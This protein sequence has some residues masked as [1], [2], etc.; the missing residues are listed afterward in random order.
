MLTPNADAQENRDAWKQQSGISRTEAKRRYITTLIDTMHQYASRSPDALELVAELEF[1][2]DQVK[3]NVPSSSSSSPL[4]K[5]GR[6]LPDTS[7]TGARARDPVTSMGF[8]Q[9]A[10]HFAPQVSGGDSAGLREASPSSQEE[11]EEIEEIGD[12][13]FVDAPDSQ[14]ERDQYLRSGRKKAEGEE[15]PVD[16]KATAVTSPSSPSDQR[17]RRRIE[18]ALVKMTAEVAALREQLESSNQISRGRR[19]T[20]FALVRWI[21]WS[22]VKLLLANLAVLSIVLLWMRRKEDK[23]LEGAV[24][25]LLGDAVAQM[26][27]VGVPQIGKLPLPKMHTKKS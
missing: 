6:A 22:A 10:R 7:A 15:E 20:F 25:V 12:E 9:D 18:R 23:R 5:A 17:W 19:R 24:R 13:E 21:A 14:Y 27:K 11:D 3:S 1:V 4:Q 26:K 2:W 16:R 8:S